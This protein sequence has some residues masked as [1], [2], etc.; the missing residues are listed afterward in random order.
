VCVC[1]CLTAALEPNEQTDKGND[2]LSEE[3]IMNYPH[4][5]MSAPST[6]CACVCVCTCWRVCVSA[7]HA[8]PW[9]FQTA[10]QSF[11]RLSMAF[12]LDHLPPL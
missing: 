12:I 9:R 3:L 11:T 7:T 1:V 5:I 6:H 4:Q 2:E 10:I 8:Y